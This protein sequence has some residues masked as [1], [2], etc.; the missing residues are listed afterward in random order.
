LGGKYEK[1]KNVKGK[2][3]KVKEKEEIGKKMRKGEVK[4]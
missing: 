1:G 3:R 2:G 4:V